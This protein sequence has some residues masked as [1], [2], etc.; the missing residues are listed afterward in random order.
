MRLTV[1][2]NSFGA[3][4]TTGQLLVNGEFNSYT[5]E[6]PVPVAAGL[7]PATLYQ[8]PKFTAKRGYPF[9]VPLLHGVPSHPVDDIEIHIGNTPLE[10]TGCILVGLALGQNRVNSSEEAF[11]RLFHRLVGDFEVEIVGARPTAVP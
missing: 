6:P 2:R 9:R 11:F 10:T 4:A 1:L 7:Y 8:S 5:L 3:H